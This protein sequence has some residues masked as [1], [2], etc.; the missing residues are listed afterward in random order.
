MFCLQQQ[1]AQQCWTGNFLRSPWNFEDLWPFV[2]FQR[3]QR[4]VCREKARDRV[5]PPEMGPGSFQVRIWKYW[6]WLFLHF[7]ICSVFFRFPQCEAPNPCLSLS[8]QSQAVGRFVFHI[9]TI[10]FLIELGWRLEQFSQGAKLHRK[11]LY[12]L[13]PRQVTN[14]TWKSWDFEITI[15]G[16]ILKSLKWQ[17]L[18]ERKTE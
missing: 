9:N 16:N 6:F 15:V 3:R 18:G 4:S 7:H 13:N 10:F 12:Q 14:F 5:D 2:F 17:L 8:T 1:S 11:F